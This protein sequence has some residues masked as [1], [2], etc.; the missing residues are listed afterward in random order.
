MDGGHVLRRVHAEPRGDQA[1][2][3]PALRHV[4]VVAEHRGHQVVPDAGDRAGA[5]RGRGRGKPA[6][7]RQARHDHVEGVLDPAAEALRVRERT[8]DPL[9]LHERAGPAVGQHQRQGI[10]AAA[11]LHDHVQAMVADAGDEL[12]PAVQARLGRAPVVAVPPVLEQAAEVVGL[13]SVLPARVDGRAG[14]PRVLEPAGQVLQDFRRDVDPERGEPR[15]G[16]A[17]PRVSASPIRIRRLCRP[18]LSILRMRSGRERA[19]EA[20]WVPPHA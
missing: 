18:L 3:V 4:A 20:R 5:D 12:G 10:G 9:E 17:H 6:V 16:V 2:P 13:D 14:Q 15:G 11:A 8:D 1:A 19:V 7:A